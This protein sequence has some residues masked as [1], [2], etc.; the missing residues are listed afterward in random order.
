MAEDRNNLLQENS[1]MR[2]VSWRAKRV[3]KLYGFATVQLPI[4][5]RLIDVPV[6][7]GKDGP[8]AV[9]PTKPEVDKDGRQRRGVDGKPAFAPVMAWCSR[10]L[11]DAFSRRVVELVRAAHPADLVPMAA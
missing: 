7:R 5:L 6:V 1:R 3:G 2:L 4:G 9:V 8:W 11:E 10:R